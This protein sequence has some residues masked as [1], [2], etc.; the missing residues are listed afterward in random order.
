MY[1]ISLYIFISDTTHIF[2]SMGVCERVERCGRIIL[3]PLGRKFIDS[4]DLSPMIGWVIQYITPVYILS[5][6][7]SYIEVNIHN[8]QHSLQN[9]YS[10]EI[11]LSPIKFLCPRMSKPSD[12]RVFFLFSFPR[13]IPFVVAME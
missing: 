7:Y 1:R 5:M 8:T 11:P 13:S 3:R 2:I 12:Q 10:H 4:L 9:Y 6:I